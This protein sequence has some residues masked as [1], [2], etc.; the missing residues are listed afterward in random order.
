MA[1]DNGNRT[2][3]SVVAFTENEIFIGETAKNYAI[4]DPI[5]TIYDSKRML[6]KVYTDSSVQKDMQSWPFKVVQG[7]GDSIKIHVVYKGEEKLYSPEQISSMVLTRMIAVAQANLLYSL[8]NV[9][10]TVP[11][12]FNDAQRLA[13]KDAGVLAG[14]TVDRIINEPTAA[15]IAYGLSRKQGRDKLVLIFD[16]GGGTFDVSILLI[17]EGVFEVKATNGDTHLGGEDFD[18]RMTEFYTNDFSRINP[19]CDLSTDS[20]A[21]RRIKAAVERGKRTL[22]TQVRTKIELDCIYKD[23]DY[24]FVMTRARFDKE[25]ISLIERLARPVETCIKDSGYPRKIINDVVMIG[26]STRIP[27]V[28]KKLTELFPDKEIIKSINPDEAVAHGAAVQGAILSGLGEDYVVIDAIPLSLGVEAEGKMNEIII[29][30]NSSV[31]TVKY[32]LFQAVDDF[33]KMITIRVFEGER[34]CTKDCHFLGQFD[35]QLNPIPSNQSRIKINFDVDADGLLEVTATD[36][37]SN[38]N[39][40]LTISSDRRTLS[41]HDVERMVEESEKSKE[42]DIKFKALVEKRSELRSRLKTAS[43]FI[44]DKKN[45]D[46]IQPEERA[47][48][49]QSFITTCNVWLDHAESE[50]I[51]DYIEKI[52]LINKKLNEA[53]YNNTPSNTQGEDQTQKEDKDNKATYELMDDLN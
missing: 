1:N 3:P 50:N 21:I 22:S 15:C 37:N 5:V 26:G 40:K 24:H 10:I 29:P 46:K 4:F 39:E 12:Y 51:E 49:F 13:T 16:L 2:S 38:K 44:Q 8:K 19:G 53:F 43:E 31:P 18:R 42:D 35:V 30:R 28:Q 36:M 23:K 45:Y 32:K 25:T 41:K 34:P 20:R 48:E 14:L 17:D 33:Q 11:A 52:T 9:V 7:P 47:K 6:G 27:A